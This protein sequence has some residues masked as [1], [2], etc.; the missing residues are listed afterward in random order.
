MVVA[1]FAN[2][3]PGERGAI[4]GIQTVLLAVGHPASVRKRS[5]RRWQTTLA[6]INGFDQT[7]LR[8]AIACCAGELNDSSERR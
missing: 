5:V 6:R 1:R 7:R 3:V 2:L 8:Y 4:A